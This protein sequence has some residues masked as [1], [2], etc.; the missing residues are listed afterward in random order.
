MA[1]LR[2]RGEARKV[3]FLHT[4]PATIGL[5]D[6]FM[7]S[8]LPGVAPVH[9]YDG[10]V[11]IDN[12][13]S[14][15]GVTPKTN[16]LRWAEFA[17]SLE[18]AGCSVVVS[19]CS[20]MPRATAFARQAVSVPVVQLDA[21]LLDR[22][23]RDFRR[24]GVITTTDHTVPYVEEGLRRRA[25]EIGKK[26]EIVFAGDRTALELFNRGEIERHD[27]I[28]LGDVADL[29]GRGVDCVLMGQIPF[30]LLDEKLRKLPGKTPV[31]YA[32]DEAFRYV[33][34]LYREESGRA[35]NGRRAV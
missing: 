27:E 26:I 35:E 17:R 10:R 19:C 30:A 25:A 22:A 20:L 5:A 11:K 7:W 6:R 13:E 21:V 15:A 8:R 24:I 33:A 16:L 14:P 28:V 2:A 23:V 9:I 18:D 4:T 12:F 3:G 34:E 32:G 31:L 29:M 1:I